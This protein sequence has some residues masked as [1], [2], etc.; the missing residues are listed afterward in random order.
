MN[1]SAELIISHTDTKSCLKDLPMLL[2]EDNYA[3][4]KPELIKCL[5]FSLLSVLAGALLTAPPMLRA[6]QGKHT[7]REL[8][9]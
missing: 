8:P 9:T 6:D 2:K 5:L 7:L 1:D 3:G 4:I